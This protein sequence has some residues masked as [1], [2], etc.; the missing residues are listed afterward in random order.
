MITTG[1]G[2]PWSSAH[3]C[4]PLAYSGDAHGE[5]PA[6]KS[7]ECGGRH[8][9]KSERELVPFFPQQQLHSREK[10]PVQGLGGPSCS[11]RHAI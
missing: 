10:S 8:W 4:H 3:A 9:E 5:M 7:L 6:P 2:Q 1:P 11:G